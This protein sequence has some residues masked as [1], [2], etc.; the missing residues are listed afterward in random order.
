MD[1]HLCASLLL[2]HLRE[3]FVVEHSVDGDATGLGDLFAE[4]PQFREY[5]EVLIVEHFPI[6]DLGSL[7][8]PPRARTAGR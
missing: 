7:A 5:R 1:I 4:I 2:D 3:L 8:R 6:V